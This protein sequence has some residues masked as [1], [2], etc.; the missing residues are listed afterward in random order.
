[1]SLLRHSYAL[2][3]TPQNKKSPKEGS[4]MFV[5]AAIKKILHIKT[6]VK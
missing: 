5:F 2:I 4:E 6:D 3:G 1:V